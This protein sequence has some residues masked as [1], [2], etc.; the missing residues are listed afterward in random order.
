MKT[1]RRRRWVAAAALSAL[2]TGQ[3][4]APIVQAQV[5]NDDAKFRNGNVEQGQQSLEMASPA[6]S[7]NAPKH[8][9]KS[10]SE[11]SC[12]GPYNDAQ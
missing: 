1:L 11:I 10:V 8:K 7:P 3:V 2:M 12:S 6:A 4:G 9:A 5:N